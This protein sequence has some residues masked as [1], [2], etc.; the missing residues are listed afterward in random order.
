LKA[1]LYFLH[2]DIEDER[3]ITSEKLNEIRNKYVNIIREIEQ[4]KVQY[5][6]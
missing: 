2:F 4:N 5:A 3:D 1:K 6:M